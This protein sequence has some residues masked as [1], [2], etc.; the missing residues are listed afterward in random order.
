MRFIF[1]ISSGRKIVPS[2]QLQ[3]NH[4]NMRQVD[5]YSFGVVLWELWER[6][7]PYEDL[8]SRFDIADTVAAGGRPTIGRGCPPPYGELIRRCWHQVRGVHTE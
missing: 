7:R 8:R 2:N 1:N 6:R 4:E 3:R 5:V